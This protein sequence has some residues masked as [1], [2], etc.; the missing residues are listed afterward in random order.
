MCNRWQHRALSSVWYKKVYL[1]LVCDYSHEVTYTSLYNTVYDSESVTTAIHDLNYI[2]FMQ[3][4]CMYVYTYTLIIQVQRR[5]NFHYV[6]KPIYWKLCNDL[7]YVDIVFI[8][9]CCYQVDRV[10][11][12]QFSFMSP[13]LLCLCQC[14]CF[15][16]ILCY[17][18][19][20]T[21]TYIWW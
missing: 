16:Y 2:N 21:V 10:H 5:D 18:F 4:Y 19:C 1:Y 7:Q 8:T 11:N 15:Q 12:T 17:T 13:F 3:K 14:I 6:S 20:S 9:V